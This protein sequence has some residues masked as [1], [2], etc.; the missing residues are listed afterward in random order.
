MKPTKT[1]YLLLVLVTLIWGNSFIAIK[2]AVHYL[3]PV[4]LTIMR[5]IPVA[6]VFGILLLP[7]RRRAFWQMVRRDCAPFSLSSSGSEHYSRWRP[8]ERR[9]LSIWCPCSE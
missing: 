1:T 6:L 8:V 5:F 3:T 9:A 4:E 7:T 2:H